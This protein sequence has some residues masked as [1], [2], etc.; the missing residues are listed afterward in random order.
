MEKYPHD[1]RPVDAPLPRL[2]GLKMLVV[3]DVGDIRELLAL[4]L[5]RAGA[6]VVTADS[7]RSALAA[8]ET[9][10]PD[11]IL[12]DLAMPDIDGFGLLE[13]V[14]E[15]SSDGGGDVD[16]IAVT[17]FAGP[18]WRERCLAAGFRDHLAKPIDFRSLLEAIARSTGRERPYRPD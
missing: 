12:T 9:A 15:L 2:E 11:V 6:N 10:R 7:A 4:V 8:I 3:D 17:G 14:R 18:S 1:L 16:V 13:R 5:A